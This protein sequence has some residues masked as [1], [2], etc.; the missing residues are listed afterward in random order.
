MSR[1]V[2]VILR[3]F[4]PGQRGLA[5]SRPAA[6]PTDQRDGVLVARA[7]QSGRLVEQVGIGSHQDPGFAG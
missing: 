1:R 3:D 4:A 2:D 7:A 6:T 5:Q